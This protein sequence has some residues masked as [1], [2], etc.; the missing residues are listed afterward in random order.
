[1]LCSITV[2]APS[3]FAVKDANNGK[4]ITTENGRIDPVTV[5]HVNPIYE[6]VVEEPAV[7]HS[8][9]ASL[10]R[11]SGTSS[12]VSEVDYLTTK[13]SVGEEIRE[14]MVARQELITVYYKTSEYSDA[15]GEAIMEDCFEIALEHT[16]IPT[17]GDYLRW[18]YSGWYAELS[19]Y[20]R[21]GVSYLTIVY[22]VAY[23]TTLDQENAVDAA[24]DNVLAR[25]EI[26]NAASDYEAIKAI[27]DYICDNVV[28]DDVNSDS[29]LLKHSAYAAVIDKTAVCQGYAL[30]FYRLALEKEI[31]AR[32]ISGDAGGPHGWNIVKIGNR[33]YN[34]DSTWD[35]KLK[36]Y[37]YPYQYFLLCDN[38]FDID[39]TRDVEYDTEAFNNQ[40]VMAT[41]DYSGEVE[42]DLADISEMKIY[43]S[44]TT[45]AYNGTEKKPKVTIPGLEEDIDFT[46]KY[47]DNINPG[48]AIVTIRGIGDYKGETQKNF[49]ISVPPGWNRIDGDWYYYGKNGKALTGWLQQAAWY[50]FDTDGKMVT[51][52]QTI[53]GQ[54]YYFDKSGV[55][56]TGWQKIDN[57]W[58][59][60]TP[61]GAAAK[62]WLQQG[63]W[64][65]FNADG[66][67]LTGLH[68]IGGNKYYFD[69]SGAMKTGWIMT[70]GSWY[71]F[72]TS[73]AAAKGWLQLGAWYYFN[74]DGIMLT[75]NQT[76]GGQKYHL[77]NSGA[78][79]T[80]W[81]TEDGAWYYYGG[82]GAV[83]GWL[84]VGGAWYYFNEE[85]RMLT[86]LQTIGGQKYYFDSSGSMKTGWIMTDGNWYYFMSSGAAAKGWL[87]QGSVWYYLDDEGRMLTG[88]Q[89]INGKTYVFNNS[90]VWIR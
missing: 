2:F 49:N 28:Y 11:S 65:Y 32:L 87:Q 57:T 62:G 88:E 36:P 19:G 7:N 73:G 52:L 51:G 53:G 74:A 69:S 77:L 54:K 70:G 75:G 15:V 12:D 59:Y 10:L 76:I 35:A 50:Y 68:I 1:M 67:M 23:F 71:Y 61:S 66:E 20:T 21:G 4:T 27:Y 30:L 43:L 85:C 79:Y 25:S 89:T 18:Q 24:V 9:T 84:R 31:D 29:Y 26:A 33:Y 38:R 55:M 60:F 72:T 44:Y 81:L 6:D 40:Y 64:Y 16:G 46:V 22:D 82:N 83:K 42:Y 39:H 45:T 13:E 8:K 47:S 3:V 58:Y 90:G 48:T 5:T 14:D 34:L 63:V 17:E 56:K 80:G 41:D 86:G 78:M 37:G